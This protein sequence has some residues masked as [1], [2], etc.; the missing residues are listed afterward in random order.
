MGST[1]FAE[2]MG[3]FHKG[4]GGKGVAPADVCLSPPPPPTGPAPIPYVNNL[5]A[6][7]LAKGSKKVT[8][9]GEPT[10]LE[11]KSEVSTSTGDEA[12][13]Q[14]GNVVTHKTKGKGF[15]TRWSFTVQIEGKGVCRHGDMMG[16]NSASPP[17]GTVNA[18][19][20]VNFRALPWVR[21]GE[22][23]PEP[24]RRSPAYGPDRNGPQRQAC[25][26]GRCW[27]C[28]ASDS[29][30]TDP[31]NFTPDHQPPLKVAW[32]AGG[33]HDPDEFEQ[34]AQSAEAVVPHCADCSNAQRNVVR[35]ISP[36]QARGYAPGILRRVA[37]RVRVLV[38]ARRWL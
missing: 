15:F 25:R 7:N 10:A 36:A 31:Q 28:G 9:Q 18:S 29:G 11:N 5:S 22:P 12:G 16:Q 35:H 19:A 3:L 30:R 23:C 17:P 2:N 38:R 1:V 8:I 34:W 33:C 27:E 21:A 4:S 26:G 24:Y 37:D 13:T 32:E 14:G 20:L 6:S